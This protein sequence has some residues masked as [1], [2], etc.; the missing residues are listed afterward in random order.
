MGTL[1]VPRDDGEPWPTLGP[2][3]WQFLTERAVHG[4][5]DLKGRPYRGDDEKRA[6]I[7]RAYEVFPQGHPMAGRRRFKQVAWSVRKGVAKTEGLGL[8]AFLELHPEAPVRCDGFDAYGQPVGRPVADP[9]IPLLATTQ[10]Q[11]AELAYGVLLVNCQEGPDADLFDAGLD[12]IVRLGPTGRA[13]GKAVPL[14]TAPD[15]RDG[16]RTTFQGFDETHRLTLPRQVE[17]YET[18]LQNVPKRVLAD[19]WSMSVTTTYTPGE[20]SVAQLEHEQAEE[21]AAGKADD[22][23]VF[24]FHREAGPEHKDLSRPEVLRAAIRE[25]SGPAIAAWP[26]FEAQVEGIARLYHQAKARGN[27]AY[28]ER[29]WL[30]RRKSSERQAFDVV[31][32]RALGGHE[33]PRRGAKVCLGLDGSRWRDATGL[34]VTDLDRMVQWKRA[35]W[36]VDPDH[37]E[38]DPDDVDVVVDDVFATF[39]VVRFYFDPAQG[40]DKRGRTWAERYGPKRVVEFYTDSR[41]SAAIG[42]ACRSYHEAIT[43]R[44]LGVVDDADFEAHI[45]AAYKRDLKIDDVDEGGN[46]TPLWTIEKEARDSLS[47]MDLSMCAVL[48]WKAALDAIKAQERVS[49]QPACTYVF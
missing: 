26:G 9:Y 3:V 49:A 44:E 29:V 34:V 22:P 27:T 20:G 7:Y 23:T 11:V 8:V 5:G 28:F 48:S 31:A 25:A 30:N 14:A 35:I 4:P 6:L 38:I 21:I 36:T 32:W 37:P 15:S 16:A 10:E 42:R 13:D 33:P 43:G 12:R 39:Q 47:L 1:V 40:W 19:A 2:Q 17:A 18:M 45:G 24:F 46:R 41:G